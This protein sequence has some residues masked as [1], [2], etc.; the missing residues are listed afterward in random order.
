MVNEKPPIPEGS[1]VEEDREAIEDLVNQTNPKLESILSGKP[2][3]NDP[4][5]TFDKFIAKNTEKNDAGDIIAVTIKG[6]CFAI[7]DEVTFG[8]YGTK[9]T[10]EKYMIL[11]HMVGNEKN[12]P[13][14]HV[15]IRDLEGEHAGEISQGTLDLIHV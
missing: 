8:Y 5:K 14:I 11:K 3:P 1:E 12:P 6:K 4:D 10:I 2:I 15:R 7:G 13:M 9:G